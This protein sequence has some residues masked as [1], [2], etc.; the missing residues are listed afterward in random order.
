VAGI[1]R[2]IK[3]AV[4]LRLDADVLAWFQRQ[5]RGYQTRINRALRKLMTEEEDLEGGR[6]DSSAGPLLE[7][8]EKGRTPS[9]FWSTFKDKPAVILPG[10]MWPTRLAARRGPLPIRPP[11]E[12]PVFEVVQG[13]SSNLKRIDTFLRNPN[14]VI[15][16]SLVITHTELNRG[17]IYLYAQSSVVLVDVIEALEVV[18][19]VVLTK[20]RQSKTY[21][22]AFPISQVI[23]ESVT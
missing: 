15:S 7:K 5:G 20:K 8:R 14:C 21:D 3:K 2:P 10:L 6:W 17:K 11:Q 4:T 9:L 19:E 16:E 1:Y 13:I 18:L 12:R 23:I 22:F